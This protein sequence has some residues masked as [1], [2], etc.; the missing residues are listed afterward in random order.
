MDFK[1]LWLTPNTASVY[2]VMWLQLDD[3]PYV[4]ETPPEVLGIIDDH[5]LEYV[6]DFGRLGADKKPERKI[7][8]YTS[9]L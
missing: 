2:M 5:W 1:A 8:D 9:W 7:P 3:E 6:T 4:L